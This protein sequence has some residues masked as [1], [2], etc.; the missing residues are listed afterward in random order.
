[1]QRLTRSRFLTR[2]TGRLM[3][4]L[5]AVGLCQAALAFNSGST[6]SDG[7]LA[8]AVN[9]QVQLPP[10]GVLNYTT[11]NIPSGVTVTF[12]RN[13]LNTPV[14]LLVSGSVTIAGTIDVRGTSGAAIGT[15]GDG[16]K[17]DDGLPGLGGPG[18]FDGGRGGQADSAQRPAIVNGEAGQGPGGGQGGWISSVP[19]YT[20]PNGNSCRENRGNSFEHYGLGGA[21]ASAGP[22]GGF[23]SYQ[24]QGQTPAAQAYGSV[25]LQPLVG[26]SGGGGARGITTDAGSGGGGGGGAILIAASGTLTITGSIQADGGDA[27]RQ[28]AYSGGGG[29][30][31]AIHLVATA[32]TG[33]G[34]LYARGGCAV[35]A[36]GSRDC[37]N[38]QSTQGAIGRIRLAAD[39][40]GFTGST[41]PSY[42]ADVAA[43]LPTGP[44]PSVRFTSIAGQQVPAQV[45]GVGDILLPST[46]SNP[47]SVGVATSRIPLGSTVRIR[48][49]PAQGLPVES[50][51]S[52]VTGTVDDGTASASVA[53]PQGPSRLEAV[54]S[55]PVTLGMN[56][57]LT[58]FAG[59]ERVRE[60]EWVATLAGQPRAVL[61][62]HSGK[63]HEVPA[64]LLRL[65]G[66]GG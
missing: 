43:A 45:T 65:V 29:S 55:F 62:T 44:V 9:L 12:K 59:N 20:T 13:A 18:G 22:D 34:Q 35:S 28:Q 8:P 64:A 56:D 6:G 32:I 10:S 21:H 14:V 47:V 7:A 19:L 51:S 40:L 48:V 4:A 53:L 27:G 58:R 38:T 52:A 66:T 49:V 61:V 1:M 60:V 63:R 42:V 24:C 31:G 46:I 23:G 16:N 26:G 50:I 57:S 2:A 3:A 11:I 36:S 37:N 5:L 41:T 17:A 25:R 39:T 33:N 15:T 30:G 54:V